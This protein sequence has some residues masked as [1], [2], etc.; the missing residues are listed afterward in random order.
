M[1]VEIIEN[2]IGNGIGNMIVNG[3]VDSKSSKALKPY[4]N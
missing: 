2:D 4:E 3:K 1:D